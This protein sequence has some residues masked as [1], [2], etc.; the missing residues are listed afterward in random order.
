MRIN[1]KQLKDTT[2]NL[3]L[4]FKSSCQ[5]LFD[6]SKLCSDAKIFNLSSF[7]TL[8]CSPSFILIH[9]IQLKI[10]AHT[11]TK[12]NGSH[13]RNWWTCMHHI[14]A[15]V[16]KN[17]FKFI[18]EIQFLTYYYRH[19]CIAP[20][21]I[22]YLYLFTKILFQLCKRVISLAPKNKNTQNNEKKKQ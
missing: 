15:R 19:A 22:M 11:H 13:L 17:V 20:I 12:K 18:E 6:K 9:H 16:K 8:F 14:I 3:I 4:S 7:Y 2:N 1:T 21:I 10:K 5:L